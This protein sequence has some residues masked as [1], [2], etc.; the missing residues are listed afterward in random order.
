MDHPFYIAGG[1]LDPEAPS[2]IERRADRQLLAG[3]LSGEFC[4]VLDTRQVGKSS[5][6]GRAKARLQEQ[7]VKVAALD[8]TRLGQTLTVS[9]WYYGLLVDLGGHLG[10]RDP[11]RA[12]WQQNQELGPMQRW[13]EAVRQV[14]LPALTSQE[15]A[16]SLPLSP[17]QPRK[18]RLIIFVDEIENVLNLPFSTDEFFAGIRECYTR[19][20]LDP[21]LRDISFCLVGSATPDSLIQD[22]RTTP[23]NIGRSIELTDFTPSEAAPLAAG[24]SRG[25]RDGQKLLARVLY[26]TNGHPY[27]T[28]RLCQAIAEEETARSRAGVDAVCESLFFAHGR[29]DKEANLSF[30]GSRILKSDQDLAGLLEMYAL[31]RR[32]RLVRDDPA[33]PFCAVLRLSGIVR[34]VTGYLWVR[35]RIY[36]RVFDRAWAQAN[37]PGAELRRQQAAYRKGQLR[38]L[39]VC[40]VV[41]ALTS[42]LT[43][44]AFTAERKAQRSEQAL[45]QQRN[46]ARR[47]AYDADMYA[48]DQSLK[49]QRNPLQALELLKMH[50]AGPWRGFSWR[51]LWSQCDRSLFTYSGKTYFRAIAYS[52]DG[53]LLAASDDSGTVRLWEAPSGRLLRA[54]RPHT[55]PAISMSF[56]PDGRRLATAGEDQKVCISD[57]ATGKRLLA[58]PA[59]PAEN[60]GEGVKTV[61]FSPN[62][63]WLAAAGCDN[64][65]T[66]WD[67]A[68]RKQARA[69]KGHSGCINMVAFSPNDRWMASASNDGTVRIWDPASGR[70]LHCLAGHSNGT[71]CLA[72]SPDSRLL[73]TGDGAGTLRLWDTASGQIQL[74][75]DLF[76][77][78]I[79]TLAFSPDGRRLAVGTHSD[80]ISLL[81]MPSGRTLMTLTGHQG[82][83]S[84]LSFS[85]KG[86]RLAS[87]SFDSTV[88]IW[89]VTPGR[90]TVQL[91]DYP[92]PYSINLIFSPNG[93]H[94]AGIDP[95]FQP[96]FKSVSI[97][98]ATTGA[99]LIYFPA[100][101]HPIDHLAYT[102]DGRALAVAS[103]TDSRLTLYDPASG[104]VLRTLR[105]P[106]PGFECLTCSPNGSSL[107]A[108][109]PDDRLE[110]WDLN[111]GENR[112]VQQYPHGVATFSIAFTPDGSHLLV[113]SFKLPIEIGALAGDW[114]PKILSR[115]SRGPTTISFSPD[116]KEIFTGDSRGQVRVWDVET[117]RETMTIQASQ[118]PIESVHLSS[119][120]LTLSTVDS[121]G[122][123]HTWR[124][125]S[126]STIAAAMR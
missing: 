36:H 42:G 59:G 122:I 64:R 12:F 19:R 9:Q 114:K 30:V 26:W 84:S 6:M 39:A 71:L 69:L 3:L 38:A 27:L 13:L 87:A 4:Y 79:D 103:S 113:G 32:R 52:P 53:Q 115:N 51:Y 89:D 111:T 16:D 102:P 100:A 108:L 17:T 40:G 91:Q 123:V 76:D 117:G 14:A 112:F 81:A 82:I 126:D 31:I 28:Q 48:A 1:T 8:L 73:A 85:R 98:D 67:I 106:F 35:N 110:L 56:S 70:R 93:A 78:R 15:N 7:G 50:A 46:A 90:D 119:D 49:Q 118:D 116:G 21:A 34:V 61:A 107:A 45:L 54:F 109:T 11:L 24:L 77:T 22:T 2:Y 60:L 47:L 43:L 41:L 23:F 68:Q 94:L 92:S 66:L 99:R 101:W 57:V 83:I 97:W 20:A 120:G 44:M 65:I 125:A 72:V 37:M 5:L 29:R 86:D 58:L 10:L 96:D 55:R 104:Q 124:A 18:P 75:D 25:G 105:A 63:R 121:K 74:R 95:D 62:G 33:N 80:T 88:K